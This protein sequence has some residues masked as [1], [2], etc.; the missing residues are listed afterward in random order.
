MITVLLRHETELRAAG[1]ASLSLFGST[2][3]GDE[4]PDSDLDLL[5]AFH[6]T[7][8]TQPTRRG[9]RSVLT[10]GMF[11]IARGGG[12]GVMVPLRAYT[13]TGKRS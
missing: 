6:N 12:A 13:L 4:R 1:V 7:G 10:P 8:Q 9:V 5:A 11:P 2:A 3:L